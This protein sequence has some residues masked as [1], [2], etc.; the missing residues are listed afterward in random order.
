MSPAFIKTLL[1]GPLDTI[2]PYR[3]YKCQNCHRPDLK[4]EF[5]ALISHGEVYCKVCMKE[6]SNDN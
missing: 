2:S 4:P 3:T 6:G 1:Q 5:V